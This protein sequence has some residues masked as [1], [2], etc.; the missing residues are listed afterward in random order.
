MQ[1]KNNLIK[2]ITIISFPI[3]LNSCASSSYNERYGS[4]KK[5]IPNSEIKIPD[6]VV[7]DEESELPGK[8]EINEAEYVFQ[9]L[10]YITEDNVK[11]E[12][13]LKEIINYLNTPYQYGG[14]SK[15]GIDC[16]AFTQNVFRNSLDIFIPRTAREQYKQWKVFDN[17]NELK[18][19][20]LIYF[21][22]S[23]KYF[24]G[25]VGIYLDDN[26]FAHASSSNGV[27]ISSLENAYYSSKF[28][29]ANRVKIKKY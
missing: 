19:G 10:S 27:I 26:L 18:F 28:V 3:I 21:D 14:N 1:S 8:I 15:E 16:S 11:K 20:D 22:T 25:H 2:I 5:N 4:S 13:F 24:P 6:S 23:R 9:R 29:G 7:E 12:K 17:E